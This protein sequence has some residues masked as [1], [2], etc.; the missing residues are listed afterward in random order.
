MQ[1][2]RRS[3]VV[4]VVLVTT[5]VA[6]SRGTAQSRVLLA[7][8]GAY[9]AQTVYDLNDMVSC[10]GQFYV[11]LV[12]ENLGN[13][14]ATSAAQWALLG[15]G[16]NVGVQGPAGATGPTGP[17]GLVGPPGPVGPTG[18]GTND[19]TKLPLAGGVLTGPVS[20]P[21]INGVI[22]AA[23]LEGADMG[24]KINAAGGGDVYIPVSSTC[25]RFTTP[26]VLPAN[27]YL[28][29]G[30]SC[31][32]YTATSGTALTAANGDQVDGITLEG[33]GGINTATGILV[34][35]AAIRF[36]DVHMDQAAGFH[37]GVTFG[38]STYLIS[39]HRLSMNHND[40]NV[41]Y[42]SLLH[43]SGE[44]IT[45]VDS[46]ISGCKIFANCVQLGTPGQLD[47]AEIE[48]I[49]THFD[50]AQV[51]NN[52]GMFKMMGGHFED[53]G[54]AANHPAYVGYDSALDGGPGIRGGAL[55]YGVTIFSD[56]AGAPSGGAWFELR[57]YASANVV[58]IMDDNP[59][60]SALPLFQLGAASSDGPFL[61]FA[62]P[63][64]QRTQAQLYSVY[65]GAEPVI[66]IE[67]PYVSQHS[68][69]GNHVFATASLATPYGRGSASMLN[70]GALGLYRWSGSGA[71]WNGVQL[72]EANWGEGFNVCGTG[73]FAFAGYGALG[74]ETTNCGTYIGWQNI[75]SAQISAGAYLGN[76]S[77]PASSS[78]ACI[79]GQFWDDAN[80]HYVCVATDTIKRAALSTF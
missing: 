32:H 74:S 7:Y 55:L 6:G 64:S 48:T 69:A 71:G 67:T 23:E 15:P 70:G 68:T 13:T 78:A 62:D 2:F 25:Y 39:F 61:Y 31:L 19:P 57:K 51:V 5:L 65:A 29:G 54:I 4:L 50:S 66:N 60:G 27:T 9:T 43:N 30:G 24:A 40:Q 10:Q 52:E 34:Q 21:S 80:Y 46:S 28:H 17:P 42:P 63:V 72:Q 20:G 26:I 36:D 11:S 44:G 59:A 76:F 41:Y 8:A 37:L 75:S 47:S 45:F 22:N 49:N 1:G 58:G 18:A 16:S 3:I 77:T 33:P 38:D 35:G 53:N 14:P 12:A 79:A 56:V 73:G